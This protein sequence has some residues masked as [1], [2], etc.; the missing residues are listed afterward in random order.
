MRRKIASISLITM[1]NI[2][3]LTFMVTAHH[4]HHHGIP[5]F[6]LEEQEQEDADCENSCCSHEKNTTCLFEQNLIVINPPKE[7]CACLLCFLHNHPDG[8]VQALFPGFTSD[9]SMPEAGK[10]LRQA[11]YLITYHSIV[12]NSGM[13]LRAPP[14]A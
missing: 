7:D 4:H 8:F 6:T 11:P 1:V 3:L 12:A 10:S 9:F 2:L 13:G 14:V 5:H